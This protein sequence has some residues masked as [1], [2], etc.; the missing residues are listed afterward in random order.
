MNAH[1]IIV[2]ST[3]SPDELVASV[4]IDCLESRSFAAILADVKAVFVKHGVSTVTVQVSQTVLV[5]CV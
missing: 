1:V 5:R 3:Q 4:H 2:L